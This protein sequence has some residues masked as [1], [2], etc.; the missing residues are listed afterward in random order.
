M[1][2]SWIPCLGAIFSLGGLIVY[3][4][5][6]VMLSKK[7]DPDILKN[8][9]FSVAIIFIT[10]IISFI[11][12]FLSMGVLMNS[13]DSNMFQF[14]P[15]IIGFFIFYIGAIASAFFSKKYL[16]IIHESTGH[17]TFDYAAKGVFWGTIALILPSLI[18]WIIAIIAF[19]TLPEYIE[20]TSSQ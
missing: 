15:M 11:I 8:F 18:G 2:L 17:K 1:V 12:Y 3:V 13:R 19:F 9:L 6:I 5:G 16:E 4:V 10:M 20:K 7:L 14:L